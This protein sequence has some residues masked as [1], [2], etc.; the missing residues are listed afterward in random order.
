MNATYRSQVQAELDE[1]IGLLREI[2]D[3][4][5]DRPSACDGFRV[6][7]IAGHLSLVLQPFSGRIAGA[8]AGSPAR[9]MKIAGEWS[10]EYAEEHT[11]AELIAMLEQRRATPTKGFIGKIDP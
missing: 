1:M 3:A 10:V 7:D 2:P 4:D 5:W 11:P 8:F 6:R 9:A